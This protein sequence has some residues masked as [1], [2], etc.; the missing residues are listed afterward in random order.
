[1]P[2]LKKADLIKILEEA[3]VQVPANLSMPELQTLIKRMD[4]AGSGS[5]DSSLVLKADPMMGL[6]DLKKAVLLQLTVDLGHVPMKGETKGDLLLWLRSNLAKFNSSKMGFGRYT[7]M[8]MEQVLTDCPAYCQW[9]IKEGT[10]ESAE[11]LRKFKAYLLMRYRGLLKKEYEETD[12]EWTPVQTKKPAATSSSTLPTEPEETPRRVKKES[13]AQ[14]SIPRAP[15]T[16]SEG[17]SEKDDKKKSKK[18]PPRRPENFSLGSDT[19]ASQIS[20]M[21][22]ADKRKRHS[23]S[24]SK[25]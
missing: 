10:R 3:E 11:G 2:A 5:K 23:K 18:G 15:E 24:E 20:W 1:M 22:I 8:S 6:A 4:L 9:A 12:E 7:E 17:E 21:E 19:E 16:E 25:K 14:P 13:S